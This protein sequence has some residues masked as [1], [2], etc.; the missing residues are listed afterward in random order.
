ME[1]ALNWLETKQDKSTEDLK[2]EAEASASNAAT[3]EPSAQSLTCDDCG[4]RFRNSSEAEYH[5]TKTEHTNFSQ[6]TEVIAPLTE[7]EKLAKL[8]A[9]KEKMAKKRALQSE[10]DKIAQKRNEVCHVYTLP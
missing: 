5:A 10:E 2:S 8:A 1:G 4:K 6:L 9:L 3:E 7:E